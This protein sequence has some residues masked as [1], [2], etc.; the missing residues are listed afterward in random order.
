[1]DKERITI[2]RL[3][4]LINETIEYRGKHLS[5]FTWSQKAKLTPHQE[6]T[7]WFFD[8][9]FEHLLSIQALSK[10][11]CFPRYAHSLVVISRSMLEGAAILN[12][13]TDGE[14]K[15]LID[16]S[17]LI[18]NYIIF[19]HL[20]E[21]KNTGK[22][23]LSIEQEF[24]KDN[25]RFLKRKIKYKPIE[26]IQDKDVVREFYKAVNSGLTITSLINEISQKLEIEDYLGT[27][28]EVCSEIAHFNPARLIR[29]MIR[30]PDTLY[31]D[32]GNIEL[33]EASLFIALTCAT[34][35]VD[36]VAQAFGIDISEFELL[37]KKF[38]N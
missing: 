21:A 16:K 12:W 6:Y 26:D 1:M 17:E 32:S 10:A 33:V 36:M 24:I 37:V 19:K 15:E 3:V 35:C 9:I 34:F 2:D 38:V 22:Q 28:Y 7:I 27:M 14:E 18:K 11:D 5:Q 30:E 29:Y 31:F 23:L 20:V 8:I 13:L 4:L 25:R